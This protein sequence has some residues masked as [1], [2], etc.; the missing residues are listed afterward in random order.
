MHYDDDDDDGYIHQQHCI[1]INELNLHLQ[2]I[3]SNSHPSFYTIWWI[4]QWIL[5][6]RVFTTIFYTSY[7]EKFLCSATNFNWGDFLNHP[8]FAFYIPIY[9]FF[10]IYLRLSITCKSMNPTNA[11]LIFD[12]WFAN[13]LSGF[14]GFYREEWLTAWWIS[15]RSTLT[16]GSAS[17][18]CLINPQVLRPSISLSRS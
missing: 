5:G 3:S 1:R 10:H 16:R 12:K 15:S 4:T 14:D 17:T 8:S 7:F 13:V 6:W 18:R 9:Q 11:V 2:I